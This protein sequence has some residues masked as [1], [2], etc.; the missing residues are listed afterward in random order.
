M[1]APASTRQLKVGREIQKDM[2]EIIRSKGMAFFGGAMVTVSEVR[3]SPD[4]S[5]AKIY[6]S[7]FPS[8]KAEATMKILQENVRVFRGELGRQVGK[9][10]RIVPELA[11]YLDSSLDYA[12]HID[13]LLKQ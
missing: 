6:V 8:A 10:F 2:A 12:Q 4:L 11:F 1:D 5:L 9:Q 7:I 13:D 3:V